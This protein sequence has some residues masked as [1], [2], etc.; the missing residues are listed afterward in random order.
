[1]LL[2]A[3]YSPAQ[4]RRSVRAVRFPTAPVMDGS[5]DDA[6]WQQAGITGDFVQTEPRYGEPATL[7][8]DVRIGYDDKA[9]YFLI[10][11]HDPQPE[12]LAA[13]ITRRDGPLEDDDSIM[14]LLDTFDDDNTGYFFGTNLLGT[15]LDGRIADNGRSSKSEWDGTWLCASQ[16]VE[17]GW[18]AELAIPF[19]T[20]RFKTGP[21]VTWGLNIARSCPRNL[22]VDLW[23]GP[24]EQFYMVSRFGDLTGLD[25]EEPR[26]KRYEIIP[27][28]ML[29]AQE[30]QPLDGEVGLDFRYRL[31]SNISAE[32]TINPDFAIIEADVE[33]INLT[34]FELFIPEKR[35]FFQEGAE[36]YSQRIRQ[37]YSRRIGDI[38]WGTKCNGKLGSWDLA[39]LVAQSDPSRFA[40]GEVMESENATYTI[41]R[42]KKSIFGSSTLGL[43][44][45]NRRWLGDNQGSLG[46]D[47]TL[48][49][50]ETLG[51]TAQFVRAHGPENNGRLAWFLRPAYDSAVTHFHVRYSDWDAGMLKNLNAVG[52]VRDDDRREFDTNFSRT[53]WLHRFGLDS[54]QVQNNYN[55]YWSQAGVLR[56]WEF[57]H[58]TEIKLSSK[59]NIEFDFTEEFKRYEKDFHN[60]IISA[61]VEYDTRTGRSFSFSY[62]F[63]ENYDSRLRL[64]T[65]RAD[66]KLTEA[67]NFEYNLTRLWLD[68]DPEEETT[69]IHVLRS[70]YYFTKDLF[71]KV[72]FQTNSVIQKKNTQVVLV[73]RFKPPFGSFQVAYQHG[74]SAFG[75][76][77]EQGHTLF[78]KLSWVF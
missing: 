63:G 77:S 55:Q 45:A 2:F 78:S 52:F 46:L 66:L 5:V 28:A 9:V 21:D 6:V 58:E 75:A 35:P 34:R 65:A 24:Q 39:V 37:F 47:A 59:W 72:F 48:F 36:L 22:E 16:R 70:N 32:L 49:F 57:D 15:Q 11:C 64:A 41:V 13:A 71:L 7:P 54:I 73:W 14:I 27:Y 62:G 69:W 29:H 17:S 56:S 74:T 26:R 20:L 4:I 40:D 53:F 8:T 50:S 1:M 33:Q 42:V 76:A 12:R 31:K 3:V 23:S 10:V 25:L 61:E 60:R 18:V 68:P 51:M 44:A 19:S 67:W 30:G 38:P 43:L